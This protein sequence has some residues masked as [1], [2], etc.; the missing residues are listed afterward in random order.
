M[1][2]LLF[3]IFGF[4]LLI[5]VNVFELL[6][7]LFLPLVALMVLFP[8]AVMLPSGVYVCEHNSSNCH[9]YIAFIFAIIFWFLFGSLGGVIFGLIRKYKSHV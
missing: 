5:I 9:Y 8:A 3:A 2:G 4:A 6:R 7:I 1:C